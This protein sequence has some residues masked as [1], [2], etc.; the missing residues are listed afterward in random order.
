MRR[1]ENFT[2]GLWQGD[3]TN[4]T[5]RFL[6]AAAHERG[7]FFHDAIAR[8]SRQQTILQAVRTVFDIRHL[9]IR[10]KQSGKF[11]GDFRDLYGAPFIGD[12][13][14]WRAKRRLMI[15]IG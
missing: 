5:V 13:L 2:N 6:Q 3:I 14:W 10:R 8:I 7:R 11:D 9:A 12:A 4:D 15:V 1:F